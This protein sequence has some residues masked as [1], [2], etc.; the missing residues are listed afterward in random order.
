MMRNNDNV[1]TCQRNSC[2]NDGEVKY[3]VVVAVGAGGGDDG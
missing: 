1:A 3:E 2:R